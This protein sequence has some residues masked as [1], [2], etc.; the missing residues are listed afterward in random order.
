[1]FVLWNTTKSKWRRLD[2]NNNITFLIYFNRTPWHQTCSICDLRASAVMTSI[3]IAFISMT[4]I[5]HVKISMRSPLIASLTLV[6]FH[7]ALKC[8]L[9]TSLRFLISSGLRM[10]IGANASIDMSLFIKS[11]SICLLNCISSW[12]WSVPPGNFIIQFS[13][14]SVTAGI[15]RQRKS[16]VVIKI[17]DIYK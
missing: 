12:H 11:C 7:S 6:A 14:Y 8:K 13:L 9:K 2:I 10:A 15:S 4:N 1:M 3:S 17:I 5:S 16:F